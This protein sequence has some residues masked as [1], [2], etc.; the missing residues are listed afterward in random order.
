MT[1]LEAWNLLTQ[2]LAQSV[3][4]CKVFRCYDVATELT[5][6]ADDCQPRLYVQLEGVE[7]TPIGPGS[8]LDTIEEVIDFT[9]NLVWKA[10]TERTREY[11]SLLPIVSKIAD[12]LRYRKFGKQGD[13]LAILNPSFGTDGELFD[14][15]ILTDNGIFLTTIG[16]QTKSRRTVK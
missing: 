11:D 1:T 4:E 10:R 6:I 3:P 5:D 15:E 14:K 12:A 13:L 16:I 9:L 2:H 8:S 7:S